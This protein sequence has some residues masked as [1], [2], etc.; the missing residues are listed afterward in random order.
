MA[1]HCAS[2]GA[3]ALPAEPAL[4][5]AP[6]VPP[7]AAPPEPDVP[8]VAVPEVPPDPAV[9]LEP[10]PPPVVE[11]PVP[12]PDVPPVPSVLSSSPQAMTNDKRS[13]I[14]IEPDE[15]S[16]IPRSWALLPVILKV[17]PRPG[18]ST[19]RRRRPAGEESER[20]FHDGR[21]REAVG[22]GWIGCSGSHTLGVAARCARSD[23]V[24]LFAHSPFSA[25]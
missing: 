8:P 15:V 16:F 4:P 5:P 3:P 17:V 14:P 19:D 13:P 1:A 24:R 7:V 9:P 21:A 2:G 20:A 10:D 22:G 11:P 12:L 25:L 6:L 18:H 23:G